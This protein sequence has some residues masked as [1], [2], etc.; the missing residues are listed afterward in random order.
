MWIDDV[1]GWTR[2]THCTIGRKRGGTWHTHRPRGV[3]LCPNLTRGTGRAASCCDTARCTL[4]TLVAIHRALTRSTRSARRF[5]RRPNRSRWA[6][7]ALGQVV[8]VHHLV[9][10]TRFAPCAVGHRCIRLAQYTRIH[11]RT[12][13][14]AAGTRRAR[15]RTAGSNRTGLARQAL[16]A[17]QSVRPSRTSPTHRLAQR[18]NGARLTCHTL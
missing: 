7:Y 3:R 2:L 4:Q 13:L 10:R 9:V 16:V 17:I 12:G 15:G 11:A 5:T 14:R 1:S 18:P 8:G 6:G